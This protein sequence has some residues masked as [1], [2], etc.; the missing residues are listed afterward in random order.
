MVKTVQC[1]VIKTVPAGG[2]NSRSG[3]SPSGSHSGP[4]ATSDRV[5]EVSDAPSG[6]YSLFGNVAEGVVIDFLA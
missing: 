6:P 2:F 4:L 5:Q 3:R 1:R